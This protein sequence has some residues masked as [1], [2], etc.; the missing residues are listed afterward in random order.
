MEL[1]KNYR[2]LTT[3]LSRFW[4]R[5]AGP[6]NW[7]NPAR[8]VGNILRSKSPA[9]RRTSASFLRSKPPLRR[10]RRSTA[11]FRATLTRGRDHS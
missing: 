8:V 3:A 11:Y 2:K 5:E 6:V 4:H 9:S 7:K 10:S 1:R